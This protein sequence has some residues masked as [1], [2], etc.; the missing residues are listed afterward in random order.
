MLSLSRTVNRSGIRTRDLQ[1][2]PRRSA[3]ELSDSPKRYFG[4]WVVLVM[5]TTLARDRRSV[6][7]TTE[8][9]RLGIE[10][11]LE[12]VGIPRIQVHHSAR[13]RP[14]HVLPQHLRSISRRVALNSPQSHAY[15]ISAICFGGVPYSR[16]AYLQVHNPFGAVPGFRREIQYP[17]PLRSL[18]QL[19]AIVARGTVSFRVYTDALPRCC[20][21][22]DLQG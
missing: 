2:V 9:E 17:A 14:L 13:L 7:L 6:Y 16:L 11:S 5:L 1:G 4:A 3:T 8:P 18:M 22:D 10:P 20:I 19:S 15:C 21:T 12:R